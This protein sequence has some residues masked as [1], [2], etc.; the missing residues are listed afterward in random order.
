MRKIEKIEQIA[1]KRGFIFASSEI[2]GG[3]SGTYDFG[4]LGT[5]LF[6]KKR[7]QYI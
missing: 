5:L 4:P 6:C 1:K 2:Y 3:L 7:R